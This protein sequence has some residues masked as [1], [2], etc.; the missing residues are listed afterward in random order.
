MIL[1]ESLKL[2]EKKMSY[3]FTHILF[4]NDSRLCVYLLTS[5]VEKQVLVYK[6]SKKAEHAHFYQ[7]CIYLGNLIL[8]LSGTRT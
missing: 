1:R 6:P 8:I 4:I 5:F 2:S 3:H 7:F